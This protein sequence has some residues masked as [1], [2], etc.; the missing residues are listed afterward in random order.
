[1]RDTGTGRLDPDQVEFFR[2]N[3]YVVGDDLLKPA[4]FAGL[5]EHFERKF[6]ALPADE[7][8]EDMDVP[9]FTDPEL[10]RWLLDPDVLDVAESILGPDIALFSAHFF[11]KPAGDGKG[12]P[13]HTDAWFWRETIHPPEQ[14]VTIWL[15]IDPSTAENGNMV[16]IPGSHRQQADG[17][18]REVRSEESVFTWE[19]DV[20][21][22]PVDTDRA[23]PIPLRPNQFS[24]HSGGLLHSSAV[25]RSTI[26]RCGF[27]MRYMSTAVRFNHEGVG[28]KHQIFLARGED[29]AGNVYAQPW[30]AYPE[31]VDARGK[32]QRVVTADR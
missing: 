31:L 22:M 12:V 28:H 3:G 7:R 10:F 20:S 21:K 23:V 18:Y 9:H 1:M 8:P 4:A 11:C 17:P 26:R 15:A 32:G 24:I 14:A 2:S 29:R 5:R 6:A 16:V 27:T 13:W 30:R 19:L 25:N